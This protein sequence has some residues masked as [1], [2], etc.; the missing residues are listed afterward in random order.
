M[1]ALDNQKGRVL[2]VKEE[3]SML[4]LEEVTQ[5]LQLSAVTVR[6]LVERG[7][8]RAHQ[9][10]GQLLFQE[11]ELAVDLPPIVADLEELITEVDRD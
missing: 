5:Q 2:T 3:L 4:T 7:V 1:Y 10:G 9:H 11:D 8:L 6:R